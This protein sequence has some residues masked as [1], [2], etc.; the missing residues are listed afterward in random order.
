MKRR[1]FTLSAL[2]LLGAQVAATRGIASAANDTVRVGVA[3][4]YP[5]YAIFFAAKELGY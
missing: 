3:A 4:S 2:S 5:T 1:G